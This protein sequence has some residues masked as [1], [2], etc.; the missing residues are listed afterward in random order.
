MDRTPHG[1]VD[2]QGCFPLGN[3]RRAKILALSVKLIERLRLVVG[4]NTHGK[5]KAIQC[6]AQQISGGAGAFGEQRA[7]RKRTAVEIQTVHR[8]Q[9]RFSGW[10]GKG[11]GGVQGAPVVEKLIQNEHAQIRGRTFIRRLNPVHHIAGRCRV[12]VE[13]TRNPRLHQRVGQA[14]HHEHERQHEHQGNGQFL[15]HGS[16]SFRSSDDSPGQKR[17]FLKAGKP[18]VDCGLEKALHFLVI[19]RDPSLPAARAASP[20][21]ASASR[22]PTIGRCPAKR[23]FLLRSC[24]DSNTGGSPPA[25]CAAAAS[26]A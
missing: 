26:P 2:S 17:I 20:W 23:Q 18:V 4:R 8:V 21:R 14:Q 16:F 7:S 24:P 22:I 10:I 25:I 11:E 5:C 15:F 19:H 12:A 6:T 9:E 1:N 13:L 3:R